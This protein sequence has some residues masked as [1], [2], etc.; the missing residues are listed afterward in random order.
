MVLGANPRRTSR[1]LS[2][3]AAEVNSFGPSIPGSRNALTQARVTGKRATTAHR[4]AT[5]PRLST[6]R[7]FP[8]SCPTP[9][10]ARASSD[11]PVDA[12]LR[13]NDRF[14]R[15]LGVSGSQDALARL[16]QRF[17]LGERQ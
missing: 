8:G 7:T 13:L 6:G 3:S 1:P 5:C 15:M 10:K 4:R 16:A 2:D 12:G 11:P 14:G 17:V 9:S